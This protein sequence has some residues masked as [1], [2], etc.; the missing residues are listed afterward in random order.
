MT[1]NELL[2]KHGVDYNK[3]KLDGNASILHIHNTN[4]LFWINDSNIFNMKRKWF[5]K[6]EDDCDNYALFLLDKSNKQYYYLHFSSKT[7]WLSNSFNNTDK[8]SLFL[9]KQI[10]NYPHTLSKIISELKRL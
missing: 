3:C 4:V 10:L 7:N 5:D 1:I 2:D 6:L 9:G 8:P